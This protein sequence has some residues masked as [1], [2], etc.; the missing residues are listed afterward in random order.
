MENK[1]FNVNYQNTF[2]KKIF[3]HH[4]ILTPIEYIDLEKKIYALISYIILLEFSYN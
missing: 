4:G 3:V 1:I 2:L